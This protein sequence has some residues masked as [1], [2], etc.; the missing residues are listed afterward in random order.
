[1]KNS[2]TDSNNAEPFQNIFFPQKQTANSNNKSEPNLETQFLSKKT[3]PD[4][5][6][7]VDH[8]KYYIDQVRDG[9][10][11]ERK[12][13]NILFLRQFNNWIKSSLI[14]K[15]CQKLD[16]NLSV[17]DLCCGKGG[18]IQ[19]YLIQNVS[20]YVGADLSAN[21][22]KN[23]INRLEKKKAENKSNKKCKF[24]FIEEDVSDPNNHLMEKIE[25]IYYF[26]LVS[27]QFALHYHF[28]KEDRVNAFLDNVTSKLCD[29]GYF[30]GTTVDANVIVKRLRNRK[31]KGN[32]FYNEKFTFGNDFYAVKFN[33]KRFLK[34]D[35]IYGIKYG[36]FLEDSVDVRNIEGEFNYV[37]EYLVIFKEFVKLCEKKGLYLVEKKNF[38]NF[39][40]DYSKINWYK[41]LFGRMVNL[42]LKNIE[43]QWEIIQLYTVFA[44]RKGKEEGKYTSHLNKNS[45][46]K[47]NDFRPETKF[48]TFS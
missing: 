20:L 36:F 32:K 34:E 35:G 4:A 33:Q 21:E 43:D 31:Y 27:C 1:M 46:I 17:L 30:I 29:G 10:E 39:Y 16:S 8:K 15:Y 24:I 14:N 22:L 7:T 3:N 28:E 44:F 45:N 38:I 2:D 9:G 19:K 25:N 40:E 18:D 6:S 41:K 47:F 12:V 11:A 42:S 5:R 48:T 26:D 13:S 23:A 37:D